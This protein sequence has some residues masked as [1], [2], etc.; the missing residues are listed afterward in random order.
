MQRRQFP[1]AI[2]FSMTIIKS[3]G[4]SFKQVG[5]YLYKLVFT[6][7]QLYVTLSR[8]KSVDGL[9]IIFPSNGDGHSARTL[10]IVYQETF[11]NVST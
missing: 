1:I 11:R 9:K 7:S 5:L 4:Q 6:H 3:Q 10:N 8:V 2:S